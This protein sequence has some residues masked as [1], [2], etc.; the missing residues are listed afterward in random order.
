MIRRF[1]IVG[2]Y[3]NPYERDRQTIGYCTKYWIFIVI[4]KKKIK[5][6]IHI[7]LGISEY[8]NRFFLFTLVANLRFLV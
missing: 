6:K 1:E 7:F 3:T 8:Y 2:Q 5:K 4:K